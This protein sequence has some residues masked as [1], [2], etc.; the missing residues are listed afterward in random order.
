VSGAGPTTKT[1][2]LWALALNE[3]INVFGA[4]GFARSVASAVRA[5]GGKVH[6]FLVSQDTTMKTWEDIPIRRVDAAALDRAP[7]WIGVF[8]REAHSDYSS[9]RAELE[10]VS[11]TARFVWPQDFYELLQ[12]ALGWRFWLHP[13]DGYSKTEIE[14]GAA[15][16]LLE[17]DESRDAFD[18]VLR[19]R[20]LAPNRWQSPT[21]TADLQY[22]PMWLRSMVKEPLHIVDAGA[23]RGETLRE[24]AAVVSMGQAWTFEPDPQNYLALV[25]NMSDW[26]A[27]ITHVPAGLSDRADVAEFTVGLGEASSVTPG[28]AAMVPMVALDECLHRA[29]VN[30]MKLDVEGHELEALEGARK[31]LLRERPVLAIAGYHRWDDLWRIPSFI[32]GLNLNY[33]LRLGL[34]AHNSFDSVFYAY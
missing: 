27:P 16:N 21:P 4:G 31:T 24:L 25:Q 33:R 10:S 14:Q 18:A 9:L 32:D 29:P 6:A 8:N 17:D 30:F 28:G 23:Y 12:D 11:V 3:G 15:R 2:E 26:D 5:R 22:M 1:H 20:Q 7:T 34:H 19:F 13:L